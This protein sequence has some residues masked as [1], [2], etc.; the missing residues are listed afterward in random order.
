MEELDKRMFFQIDR[1]YIIN[2][3]Y[4]RNYNNGIVTIGDSKLVVS[5]RRKKEFEKAYFEFDVIHGGG[6]C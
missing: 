1:K 2:M 4:V 5:R 6:R 3:L